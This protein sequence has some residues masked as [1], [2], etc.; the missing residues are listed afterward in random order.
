MCHTPKGMLACP[1]VS[2]KVLV[3]LAA[4]VAGLQTGVTHACMLTCEVA[5]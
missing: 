2:S 1:T 3:Y 5:D 4:Q